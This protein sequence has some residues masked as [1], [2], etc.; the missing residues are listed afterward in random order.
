MTTTST[1]KVG[2]TRVKRKT[3]NNK[4]SKKD[5]KQTK[6]EPKPRDEPEA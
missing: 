6:T 3:Q 4:E 1:W 2:K 5:I